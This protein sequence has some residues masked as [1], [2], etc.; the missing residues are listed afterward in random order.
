MSGT[1]EQ[2]EAIQGLLIPQ[3]VDRVDLLNG[4]AS[5]LGLTTAQLAVAWSLQNAT[6]ASTVVGAHVPAQVT[7]NAKAAGVRLDIDVLTR[8]D[9]LLGSCVCTDPRLVW[10]PPAGRL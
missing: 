6:V 3:L 4:V 1:P 5:D 8:I 2:R 7:E 10:A 9:Q